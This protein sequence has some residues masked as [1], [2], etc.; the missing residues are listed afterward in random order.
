MSTVA[1]V[2]NPFLSK[3]NTALRRGR[4]STPETLNYTVWSGPGEEHLYAAVWFRTRGCRFDY[5]GQ[6]TMC[7]YW[8]STLP[9]ADQMVQSCREALATL[10]SVPATLLVS[11]S[12][13][14][15][16]EWEVPAEARRGIF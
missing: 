8:V 6:C 2:A 5:R 15:F 7:D 14:M 16:D 1:A 13:S 11:P 4:P 3:V 12:G 10:T 9:S